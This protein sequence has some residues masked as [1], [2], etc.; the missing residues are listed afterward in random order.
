MRA[1][2]DRRP[3]SN[4]PPVCDDAPV[5]RPAATLTVFLALAGCGAIAGCGGGDQV[6]TL[7]RSGFLARAD[8]I[9]HQTQRQFDQVQRTATSTPAQAERQVEALIEVSRQALS[10][11]QAL[12]PPPSVRAS[13]DRYLAS[14]ERAIGFLEDGRDAAA[15]RDAQAYLEAKRKVSSDLATRLQLARE[16][17]LED[18]SRPSVTFG[19]G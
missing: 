19:S 5:P 7:S 3:P 12:E 13:Y 10:N 6:T 8:D 4:R 9:C 16:V 17:G 18:C 2:S 11:L 14:R 1:E 15:A